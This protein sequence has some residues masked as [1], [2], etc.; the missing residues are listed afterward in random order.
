MKI[1][2]I[3][4]LLNEEKTV[5][6]FLDSIL[7]QTRLPDEIIIVD[8]ESSD[9]T[10]DKI[11]NQ[12]SKIKNFNCKFKVFIKKGDR[13]VG[14]NQ[15]IKHATGDIIACS[16][17]GNILDKKW[18]ENITR[19]FKEKNVDVVAGY[20]KGLPRNVFQKCLI[21]YVL[22]MPDKVNPDDFLPATRSIAFRKVIWKK[23]GG[24]PE[25]FSHNE[26]YIFANRLKKIKANIFFAKDAVVYW[27]P[28]KNYKESF[29]MFFRF[30]LGDAESKI[31]RT[32]ILLL[33]ARY[34]FG[35]YLIFLSLLYKSLIPFFFLLVLLVLYI[36]W[37]ICK[38][39]KYIND[40]KAL[41]ILPLLQFTADG[42]VLIGT[43][44]GVLRSMKRLN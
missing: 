30:S 42:A 10:V 23:V 3:T 38:N 37:S 5:G 39:Y 17:A 6:K 33:F 7:K 19:P 43:S 20:Y 31:I 9:K 11:E 32:R 26:D 2:L 4:T 35:L 24:F 29:I 27:I 13:S 28:R 14:R 16:D 34:I 25:K 18:V 21:P 41:I 8:G 12:K 44:I 22:V 15:A 40:K 36:L 1:S